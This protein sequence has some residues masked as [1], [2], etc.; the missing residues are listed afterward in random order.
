MVP[1]IFATLKIKRHVPPWI[2]IVINGKQWNG[3][4]HQSCAGAVAATLGVFGGQRVEPLERVNVLYSGVFACL[5]ISA[6]WLG[7]IE[8]YGNV[9]TVGGAGGPMPL[10]KRTKAPLKIAESRAYVPLCLRK[11]SKDKYERGTRHD[12]PESL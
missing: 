10:P 7:R 6:D 2:F 8:G 3:E 5:L 11:R 1:C 9:F 4:E 12:S